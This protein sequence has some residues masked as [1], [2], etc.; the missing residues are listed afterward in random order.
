MISI[1]CCLNEIE[2]LET[3]AESEN[4]AQAPGRMM[5]G[6]GYQPLQVANWDGNVLIPVN[7]S[8][9]YQ[10]VKIRL[11]DYQNE[12]EFSARILVDGQYLNVT[13]DGKTLS[14]L[15]IL[16]SYI[17]NYETSLHHEYLYI[18]TDEYDNILCVL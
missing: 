1:R 17:N 16:K 11:T 18:G 3:V 9:S 6:Y 13:Y 14:R 12:P 5:D 2:L 10:Q 8:K 4:S 7:T 15:K